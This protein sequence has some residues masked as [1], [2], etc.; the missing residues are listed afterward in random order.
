VGYDFPAY[1]RPVIT[2]SE[3]EDRIRFQNDLARQFES[4]IPDADLQERTRPLVTAY[5]CGDY[6]TALAG[7]ARV[8][9]THP[10]AWA[11]LWPY[12]KICSRVVD[13][14][15][16]PDDRESMKVFNRWKWARD[17][18]PTRA[19]RF[20]Y[21]KYPQFVRCKY[22]ARYIPYLDPDTGVACGGDNYCI[23]CKS[24]YPM[25]SWYWDSVN[26]QAYIFYRRSV[27]I[28]PFYEDFLAQFDV[29]EHNDDKFRGSTLL[30][31]LKNITS[32]NSRLEN[33]LRALQD[34]P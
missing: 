3:Y 22:C 27:P 4:A 1:P 32:K 30:D 7:F 23:R 31:D 9:A 11:L 33:A 19:F 26:G 17:T 12:V 29:R 2:R 21:P 24:G 25:P 10:P 13:K 5:N 14:L 6:E 20:L 15:V 18:M 16:H 28:G 34:P 8:V